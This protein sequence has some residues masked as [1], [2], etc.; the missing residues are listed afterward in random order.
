MLQNQEIADYASK[1]GITWKFVTELAP[2][3]GGFY[4]RLVAPVK[5]SLKKVLGPKCVDLVELQTI[6]YEIA[7]VI[8][9]R[10]LLYSESEVGE[11]ALTPAH[12]L[13]CSG[14][15]FASVNDEDEYIPR[16]PARGKLILLWQRIQVM[17]D[18]FWRSWQKDYL[19]SLREEH[20]RRKQRG[21][22]DLEPSPGMTVLV[23]DKLP[24][25]RW[26]LGRIV[27]LYLSADRKCR[28]ALVLLSDRKKIKRPIKLL[29]PLEFSETMPE[30]PSKAAPRKIVRE[31][32]KRAAAVVAEEKM[33][34]ESEDDA[35]SVEL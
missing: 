15:H 13:I 23:H 22:S 4:E 17:L 18:S 1:E 27:E 7:S 12:F 14:S 28:S 20:V 35:A 29:Y 21:V 5:M 31:V 26:K 19:L 30:I 24:R 32:P 9:T 25:A 6:V 10:P 3:M 8:N 33:A 34:V 2:W 16:K 11:G